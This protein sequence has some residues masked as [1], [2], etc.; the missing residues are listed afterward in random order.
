MENTQAH[1]LGCSS[2]VHLLCSQRVRTEL[3][4]EAPATGQ[5]LQ[6]WALGRKCDELEVVREVRCCRKWC[7]PTS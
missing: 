5:P 2:E 4:G 3:G 7:P 6:H 1:S